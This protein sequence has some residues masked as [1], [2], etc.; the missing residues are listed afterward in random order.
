MGLADKYHGGVPTDRLRPFR[1]TAGEEKPVLPRRSRS[2]VWWTERVFHPVYLPLYLVRK[3]Y[4]NRVTYRQR[5]SELIQSF[6]FSDHRK[7]HAPRLRGWLRM[8]G[9]LGSVMM[10]VLTGTA[11]VRL[12]SLLTNSPQP[13]IIANIAGAFGGTVQTP[14]EVNQQ[15]LEPL[16]DGGEGSASL[17]AIV[18]ITTSGSDSNDGLSYTT[19]KA[20]FAGAL[21]TLPTQ[22]GFS[23]GLIQYGFGVFDVSSFVRQ[24]TAT[25]T[26]GNAT[27]LDSS[28]VT[29]D[30]GRFVGGGNIPDNAYITSVS[31]GVSFTMNVPAIG[32]GTNTNFV[33]VSTPAILQSP[34]LILRGSGCPG[35]IGGQTVWPPYAEL[36][37]TQIVDTGTG[38]TIRLY[39]PYISGTGSYAGYFETYG[40]TIENMVVTGSSS[41]RSGCSGVHMNTVDLNHVRFEQHGQ[42]GVSVGGMPNETGSQGAWVTGKHLDCIANGTSSATG[43][44]GG[45]EFVGGALTNDFNTCR[46]DFNYGCNIYNTA[47]ATVFENCEINLAKTSSWLVNGVNVSGS[48]A[49]HLG[50]ASNMTKY[51]ECWFEANQGYGV[52]AYLSGGQGLTVVFDGTTWSGDG[53]QIN[54]LYTFGTSGVNASFVFG[55]GCVA[56]GHK[57]N[58]SVNNTGGALITWAQVTAGDA[59]G[60]IQQG[61]VTA[62]QA[63]LTSGPAFMATA[64]GLST[65]PAGPTSVALSSGTAWRNTTGSDVILAI[66]ISFTILGGS[67]ALARSP[68]NGTLGFV[69]VAGAAQHVAS[70]ANTLTIS[71]SQNTTVGNTLVLCASA[72]HGGAGYAAFTPS[73]TDTQGNTWVIDVIPQTHGGVSPWALIAHTFLNTALTTSDSVTLNYGTA[74]NSNYPVGELIE[75]SG[76]AQSPLDQTAWNGSVNTSV[77][78]ITAGPTATTTLASEIAISAAYSYAYRQATPG[79][80]TWTAPAG[81]T[82]A[83]SGLASNNTIDA[84]Y[85][86]LSST[87]TVTAA[88]TMSPSSDMAASISTFKNGAP[89][90]LGTL[91]GAA[92]TTVVPEY[93]VPAGWFFTVTLTNATFP[94]NASAQPA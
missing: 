41:N 61:P 44:T 19:G 64:G 81:F 92:S 55:P 91:V 42:W 28:S 35:L 8:A 37:G 31:V 11:A 43:A 70:P 71:L 18:Y 32:A 16:G 51:L 72:Q 57:S 38:D 23:V 56:A 14:Q 48:G 39:V 78:T 25:I 82:E 2:R 27:V 12:L 77:T 66:P 29:A 67:A 65:A 87:G 1:R 20:T 33:Y 52:A 53:A 24:D 49:I 76:V 6:G 22:N 45:I 63:M 30:V 94:A 83:P 90:S 15:T 88:W 7:F 89:P 34:G 75:L 79:T 36:P 69:Q 5:Q 47:G 86:I 50:G 3:L 40:Y 62:A 17:G 13:G 84:A 21:A 73:V 4:L 68:V 58:W 85:E 93:Y 60:F 54:A 9:S 59:N 80:V 74:S 26:S 10:S 46:F